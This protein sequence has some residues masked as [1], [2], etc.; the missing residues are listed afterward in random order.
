MSLRRTYVR[1]RCLRRIEVGRVALP[2][3]LVHDDRLVLSPALLQ[4]P[5]QPAK[6]RRR[7]PVALQVLLKAPRRAVMLAESRLEPS[8]EEVREAR[9]RRR[10][11][12]APLLL[13][14]CLFDRAQRHPRLDVVGVLLEYV[15]IQIYRIVV[16]L[17][18]GRFARALERS[19]RN[20]PLWP[21]MAL[22]TGLIPKQLTAN[23]LYTKRVSGV[24]EKGRRRA[25]PAAVACR[26]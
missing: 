5:R 23:Y 10:H 4:R 14:L 19:L 11:R 15:E 6:R 25:L 8:A 13:G 7:E 17:L 26:P 9:D 2:D 1:A 24:N 16:V 20:P 21:L 3:R 18:L 22:I 12:P